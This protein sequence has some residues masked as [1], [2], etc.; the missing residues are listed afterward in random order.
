MLMRGWKDFSA[1][2]HTLQFPA[3]TLGPCV[4]PAPKGCD[5]IGL[6][7]YYIHMPFTSPYIHITLKT[8]V[9]GTNSIQKGKID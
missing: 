6:C 1:R 4:T 8:N 2:K 5:T 7:Q 9:N 3:P